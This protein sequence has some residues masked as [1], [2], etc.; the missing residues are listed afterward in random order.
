VIT[1]RPE[2]PLDVAARRLVAGR[3]HRLV[4]VDDDVVVGILSVRDLLA[5]VKDRS[6]LE[7]VARVMTSPVETVDVGAT[8]E[9]ALAQLAAS[10]VHGLVVV[11]GAAPIGVFTH[12]E[13]LA[14]RRLPRELRARPVEDVMSSETIC[15]D[16]ATPIRRAAAHAASMN[17]RR[18]LVTQQRRLVGIASA[19]DLVDVL[20]RACVEPAA[21]GDVELGRG[22]GTHGAGAPEETRAS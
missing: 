7:P 13:A 4:V 15:V 19:I 14:V 9:E 10:N 20:C 2:D 5:E 21:E 3:V 8:A 12:A 18:L 22:G 17:V 1:V 6:V 11:E 16:V